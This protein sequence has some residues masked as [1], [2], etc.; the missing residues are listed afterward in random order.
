M[1]ARKDANFAA[2]RADIGQR[3][4]SR[5]RSVKALCRDL[6][7]P[8]LRELDCFALAPKQRPVRWT[9]PEQTPNRLRRQLTL[10]PC[11]LAWFPLC[12]ARCAF[13]SHLP[14]PRSYAQALIL[15]EI[16]FPQRAVNQQGLAFTKAR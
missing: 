1:T 13:L 12:F 15:R 7:S 6:W 14:D 3:L 8:R 10:G 9:I 16:R 2:F 4:F 11:V 5:K